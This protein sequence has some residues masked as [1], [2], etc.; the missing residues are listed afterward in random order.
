[1]LQFVNFCATNSFGSVLG[2][3]NALLSFS[4]YTYCTTPV[5]TIGVELYIW[6]R[7]A[8]EMA[9]SVEKK[10]KSI[11]TRLSEALFAKAIRIAKSKGTTPSQLFRWYVDKDKD[12]GIDERREKPKRRK[13]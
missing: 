2:K 12:P 4:R 3:A 10:V 1:M 9:E 8:L 7:D 6:N 11:R 5:Y 13:K